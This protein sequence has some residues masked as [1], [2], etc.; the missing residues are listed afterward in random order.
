[1]TKIKIP[2]PFRK[3]A[4]EKS[5]VSI[6]GATV[7]EV[8]VKLV[9]AYPGLSRICDDHGNIKRSVNVYLGREDVRLLPDKYETILRDGDE[10]S[11]VPA[12]AGG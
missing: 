8:I 11:L 5:E 3:H 7:N 9:E 2:G 4:E 10:L 6:Y 1:M 12:I